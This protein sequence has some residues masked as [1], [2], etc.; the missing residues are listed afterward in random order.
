MIRRL[1]EWIKGWRPRKAEVEIWRP[2]VG[3]EGLYEVSNLGRVRSIFY[4][5]VNAHPRTTPLVLSTATHRP[6]DRRLVSL[7][8]DKK[9]SPK[10]VHHLMLE[11]FVGPRPPGGVAVFKSDPRKSPLA[12]LRW[13]SREELSEMKSSW[14]TGV[15]HRHITADQVC[16]I[17]QA[18]AAG[19][20]RKAIAARL[21]VARSTINGIA[22]HR[23]WKSLE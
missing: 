5:G 7:H 15:P 6:L 11:A 8:R 18:V 1:T 13:A 23:S 2:V 20:S 14:G 9:Q 10:R 3:Y 12:H 16:A 4:Q 17:R 22:S 21:G 19:E